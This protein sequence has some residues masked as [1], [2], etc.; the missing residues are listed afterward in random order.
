MKRIIPLLI[1]MLLL[2]GC[3]SVLN[4][5]QEYLSPHSTTAESDTEPVY[6]DVASYYELRQAMLSLVAGHETEGIIRFTSYNG[7]IEE[8]LNNA[9]IFITNDTAIGSYSVSYVGSSLNRIVSY[10]EANISII[11]KKDVSETS[12]IIEINTTDDL[13]NVMR[14]MMSRC[15]ESVAVQTGSY[16][17][18]QD[19]FYSVMNELYYGDPQLIIA[20]PEMEIAEYADT[21]GS[22]RIYDISMTYADIPS[23]MLGKKN[24]FG[25]I[26]EQLSFQLH[27]TDDKAQLLYQLCEYLSDSAEVSGTVPDEEYDQFDTVNTAY[28]ALYER[29]ASGEGFAMAMKLLCDWQDIECIVVTGRYNNYIHA[30]NMIKV[31]DEWYHFDVSRLD[32]GAS[33]ALMLTDGQMESRYSWD[34]N[35]YPVCSG[36]LNYYYLTNA[37]SSESPDEPSEGQGDGEQTNE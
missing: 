9:C 15:T 31:D 23:V 6:I 22:S 16:A 17:I 5:S 12:S 4:G 19:S 36:S 30:W 1:I 2:C 3:S 33:A 11:Y 8:D 34:A 7:N 28:G 14:D 21:D 26:L 29:R 25:T 37:G 24:A 35:N 20:L 10:Y 27:D 32:V 18:N 13:K